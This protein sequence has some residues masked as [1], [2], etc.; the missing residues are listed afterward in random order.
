MPAPKSSRY[1]QKW[2]F[3]W[4]KLT[5]Q[6]FESSVQTKQI[7]I[8]I[9]LHV[10]LSVMFLNVCHSFYLSN[11]NR[12]IL[13]VVTNISLNIVHLTNWATAQ[14][15]WWSMIIPTTL[16]FDYG[17]TSYISPIAANFF[18]SPPL[19]DEHVWWTYLS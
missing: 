6:Y 18:C 2:T 16:T 14:A 11:K 17:R 12:I 8:I 19:C 1:G 3:L 13:K 4:Q 9:F 7:S 10:C 5:K 15:I